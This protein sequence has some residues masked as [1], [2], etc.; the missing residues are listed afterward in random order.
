MV[1]VNVKRDRP[2]HLPRPTAFVVE[3]ESA[4]DHQLTWTLRDPHPTDV[5]DGYF[6]PTTLMER[7][8]MWLEE[9]EGGWS[10]KNVEDNVKG[11][12]TGIRDALNALRKEGYITGTRSGTRY[13]FT[14]FRAYREK[15]DLVPAGAYYPSQ[16]EDLVPT[17]S[18]LVPSPGGDLVPRPPS[19]EGDEVGR[20]AGIDVYDPEIQSAF[21]GPVDW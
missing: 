15:D 17:S 12:G 11:K 2:G 10:Q 21:D 1:K 13:Q 4:P 6:R 7:V 14:H 19:I 5:A 8:S 20:D 18:H 3:L 16:N 9:N